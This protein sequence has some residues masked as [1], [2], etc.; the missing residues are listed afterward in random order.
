MSTSLT[1]NHTLR[2]NTQRNAHLSRLTGAALLALGLCGAAAASPLN[3]SWTQVGLMQPDGDMF[4]GN[5]NLALSGGCTFDNGGDYWK[6]FASADQILFITGDGKWWGQALASTISSLVAADAR[7]LAP[8]L[9]WI[10]AG[11]NGVS[12]G[13][14]VG[15]LLMRSSNAEDPWI[16]LEGGHCAN[17]CAEMLW[18]ENAWIRSWSVGHT[19]VMM[20]HGGVEVYARS[21]V[22]EPALTTNGG[23]EGYAYSVVPEPASLALVGLGL[24]IAGWLR[25]E[26]A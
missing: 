24:G 22:P 18:A 2:M 16:T 7:D 8:N 10:D 23:G 17:S 14:A 11:R 9:Q 6:S 19:N 1:Q 12:I 3:A 25:R 21:V 15:N 20:A 4:D 26:R 5:C 13:A